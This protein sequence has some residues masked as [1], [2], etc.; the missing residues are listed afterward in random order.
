MSA[1]LFDLSGRAALVTG[2]TRG[3]GLAIA[4][5]LAAAGARVALN[6]RTPAQVEEQVA[7][8]GAEG[9]SAVAAPFDVSDAPAVAAALERLG[10]LDILVNNAGIT[11][12]EALEE[13]SLEQWQ[14]ILDVNL[15]GAFLVAR[16]VVP[17]MIARRRG[18][19]INLCSVYSELARR[20]IAPYTASKGA[21]RALTRAMCADWAP[22]GIQVNAIGPGYIATEL[23]EALQADAEFGDWLRR[24][25]PAGRWGAPSDLAGAAVFLASA[26][27]DFV[28]G[29]VVYVDGGLTAVV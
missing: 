9:L 21:L 25:V 15:T 11:R 28:N 13:V 27:S 29:Q 4:R 16:A 12:R 6:G 2:S 10:P 17:G 14:L 19:I 7:A 3:I 5:A 1:G 24:R 20:T 23:T 22:H 18:K 8:L 26:A